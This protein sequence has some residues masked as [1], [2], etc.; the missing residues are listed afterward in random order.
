MGGV[1]FPFLGRRQLLFFL[2]DLLV[3]NTLARDDSSKDTADNRNNFNQNI[4][5]KQTSVLTEIGE[6][7]LY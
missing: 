7:R 2:E 5:K 4:T 1:H 6:I 3:F